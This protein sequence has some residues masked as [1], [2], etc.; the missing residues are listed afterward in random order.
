V[1][2]YR[3]VQKIRSKLFRCCWRNLT[4]VTVSERDSKFRIPENDKKGKER[5]T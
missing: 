5:L 4:S 1:N 3:T 2:M